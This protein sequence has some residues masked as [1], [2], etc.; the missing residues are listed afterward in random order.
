[1]SI[2]VM[3]GGNW[4]EPTSLKVMNSGSWTTI[5]DG[6]VR[7]GGVWKKFYTQTTAPTCGLITNCDFASDLSGW[8][9]FSGKTTC[10]NSQA[11]MDHTTLNNYDGL[12]IRQGG[13]SLEASKTYELKIKVDYV[14]A[15]QNNPNPACN[16]GYIGLK[17]SSNNNILGFT[18]LSTT[19][20]HTFSNLSVSSDDDG[21]MVEF[22]MGQRYD[23]YSVM[24][25]DGKF[26]WITLNEE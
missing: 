23:A 1:M 15:G 21:C 13:I 5:T 9:N 3:D 24:P 6:W 7:D 25:G 12:I 22:G 10:S 17:D 20:I 16:Y 26:D 8:D 19:G 2:K 14:T 11:V 18:C 4:K